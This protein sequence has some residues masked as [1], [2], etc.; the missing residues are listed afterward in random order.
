ML[1]NVIRGGISIGTEMAHQL[2]VLQSLMFNLLEGQRCTEIDINDQV[3]VTNWFK[4]EPT[5]LKVTF[6]GAQ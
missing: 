6:M 5:F 2:Y 4:K 3:C 1:Q